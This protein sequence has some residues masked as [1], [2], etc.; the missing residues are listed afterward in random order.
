MTKNCGHCEHYR[1]DEAWKTAGVCEWPVPFWIN[2][3]LHRVDMRYRIV[4]QSSGVDCPV[5]KPAST[6]SEAKR[7]LDR[8]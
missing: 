5:W 3:A 4:G 2:E 6:Q 8:S 1:K 7:A